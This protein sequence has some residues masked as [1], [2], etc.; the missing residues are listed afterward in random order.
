MKIEMIDHYT[1]EIEAESV[2]DHF[3]L[4]Q[5]DNAIVTLKMPRPFQH[6]SCKIE[7]K[8]RPDPAEAAPEVKAQ[9][10]VSP[11]PDIPSGNV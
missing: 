11:V 3:F 8:V 9:V 1:M 6:N 5:F 4:C 10:P 2:A 7:M